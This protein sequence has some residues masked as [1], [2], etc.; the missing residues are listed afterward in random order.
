MKI[1]KTILITFLLTILTAGCS[2]NPAG[3]YPL[4]ELFNLPVDQAGSETHPWWEEAVFYEIFVRSFFDSDA[5]GIGDFNGITQKLDYLENLGVNAIWLMPI[6]PS[7]SYHGYDVINYYAVN[8]DYGTMADFKKLLEEVHRRD[9][10]LIIDLVLNH[11][12]DQ[13]PF[14]KDANSSPESDYR[15]WYIWEENHPGWG[16]NAWHEGAQGYYYGLFWAGMPD[17]NYN[18]PDVTAQM[19]QVIRYWVEDVGVDGFRLDAIK[20]LIEEDKLT[21]NVPSTHE[22]LRE[23]NQFYKEEFPGI[24]I[25]GEV[26]GAGGY[27]ASIYSDDELDQVFNF[28][29][30]AGFVNSANGGS[31]TG[32]K[33]AYQLTLKDMPAGNYATFLANHDQ[34]RVLSVLN[35][36]VGKAKVA[37]SLLLTAPGTPFIYYGEEIGLLGKKP[38][39]DLR[40]P[41]QWS[42]DPGAGFS[43]TDAWRSVNDDYLHTNVAAQM[44]DQDGLLSHY[45]SLIAVRKGHPALQTGGTIILDTGTP[46]VFAALRIQKTEIILT[47]INLTDEPVRNFALSGAEIPLND[48]SYPLK[49]L[50]SDIRV[51]D[52]DLTAG[53]MS[54]FQP[55]G[56]LPP[57]STYVFQIQ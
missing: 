22:W 57:Y 48:G 3:N 56:E 21:E 30:A 13:H 5:D 55:V 45:Q 15:E 8:P 31:N 24:Y 26:F 29:L 10:H 14:F 1:N 28:E 47:L 43:T 2:F 44:Y 37:A 7:P 36:N 54:D 32:I 52:L 38:D 19:E 16:G 9:M 4:T 27:L 50:L 34:N 12:S 20:H 35:G 17:L 42:A 33:S 51:E 6:H 23:F 41:M 18:N 39:E 46:A 40:L 11:T 25:V 49:P 53:I